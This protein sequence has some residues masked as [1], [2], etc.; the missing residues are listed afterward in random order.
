MN[1]KDTDLKQM[2]IEDSKSESSGNIWTKSS[3]LPM[4]IFLWE[5]KHS[6][7]ACRIKVQKTYGDKVIYGKFTT[8][9]VEDEPRIIGGRIKEKDFELIKKFISINKKALIEYWNY[10]I[11]AVEMFVRKLKKI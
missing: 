11:D 1:K 5:K 7:L 3:G 2:L 4:I 8:V 9:T 6:K 10:E